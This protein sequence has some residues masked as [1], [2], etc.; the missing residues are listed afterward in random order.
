MMMIARYFVAPLLLM[1]A[2]SAFSE[3]GLGM[4]YEPKYPAGFKHFDYV[5]PNAPKGGNLS[6]SAVGTFNK[7]N[8]FILKGQMAIGMGWSA[9]G[10][11][12]AESGLYFESLTAPSEDEPFTRYGLLAQDMKLA[13]DRLSITFKLHPNAKFSNGDAVLAKDVKHS[14]ETLIG[15]GATPTFKTYWADVK[16]AVIVDDRT[17]RFDFKRVNSELHMVVGQLPVFSHKWP[18]AKKLDEA[19]LD[20]P[21]GSGP[22]QIESYDL[23][24]TITY[25]RNKN[26]WAVNHPT[27]LGTYNFDRVTYSYF[28]DPT[29]ELEAVNAGQFDAKDETSIA[30]W[31][32]RYSGKAFTSGLLRKDEFKHSRGT[33]MQGLVFNIRRDKFKDIR[34]RRAIGLAFDFEWLNNR[35]F[36][37]RRIRTESYLSGKVSKRRYRPAY[38]NLLKGMQNRLMLRPSGRT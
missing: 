5:N 19:V 3:H 15:K 24:K 31:V 13:E 11:V 27:R 34:V 26:Y 7:L 23:G 37:N 20:A 2:S 10:F 28:R 22:Y 30:N 17:I 6:L 36:F 29:G 4:G 18:G 8:P 38:L 21:I 25:A 9:N 16:S 32:R 12:F 35:L 33:G 14:F 1:A